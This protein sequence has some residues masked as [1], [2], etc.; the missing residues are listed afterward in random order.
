MPFVVIIA[1]TEEQYKVILF[2]MSVLS[3]ILVLETITIVSTLYVMT[4]S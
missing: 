2:I 1:N 4:M 3:M